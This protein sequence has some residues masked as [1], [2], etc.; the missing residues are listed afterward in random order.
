MFCK[1]SFTDKSNRVA[2]LHKNNPYTITWSIRFNN[3]WLTKIWQSK[4]WCSYHSILQSL[5]SY[6]SFSTPLDSPRGFTQCCQRLCHFPII[7]YK[8]FVI[9]SQAQNP[10]TNFLDR[11]KPPHWKWNAQVFHLLYSKTTLLLLACNELN[12]NTSNTT[13]TCF[14]C[15]S[16]DLL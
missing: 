15:A 14:K 9:P 13:V 1:Q 5:K 6:I 8:P 12:L 10:L 16:N 7:S 2:L 4:Y 3:K 11:W